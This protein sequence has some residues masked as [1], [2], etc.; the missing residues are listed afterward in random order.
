[1]QRDGADEK[2]IKDR[3]SRQM[4]EE[5]KMKRCDFILQNNEEELLIPQVITLYK[6]LVELSKKN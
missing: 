1:M 6:K 2:A 3:M 4:N 5:E